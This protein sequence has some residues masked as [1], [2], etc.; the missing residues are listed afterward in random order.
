M[1]GACFE[2]RNTPWMKTLRKPRLNSTVVS[3]AVETFC[4]PSRQFMQSPIEELE[5]VLA[6]EPFAVQDIGG[7]TEHAQALRLFAIGFI[8]LL[9]FR[10]RL[11]SLQLL[12]RQ[13]ILVG[14]RDA[15]RRVG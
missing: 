1:R 6:P 13:S 4:R 12:P 9:H 8:E 5:A 15:H 11:R 7:R 3:V 10:V 14:H 2:S